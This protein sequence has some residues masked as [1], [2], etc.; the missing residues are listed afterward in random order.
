MILAQNPSLDDRFER[1]ADIRPHDQGGTFDI[2]TRHTPLKDLHVRL[3]KIIPP[4]GPSRHTLIM[5]LTEKNDLFS[6]AMAFVAP[7]APRVAISIAGVE[8]NCTAD[9]GEAARF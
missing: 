2:S 6:T 4:A 5:Q 8:A 7:G 1:Y 9:D 3:L